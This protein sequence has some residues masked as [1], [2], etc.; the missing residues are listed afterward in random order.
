MK[1]WRFMIVIYILVSSQTGST[2]PNKHWRKQNGIL[3]SEHYSNEYYRDENLK[4]YIYT[5]HLH[6]APKWQMLHFDVPTTPEFSLYLKLK[7]SNCVRN[8][9]PTKSST[10]SIYFSTILEMRQRK[11]S[12]KRSNWNHSCTKRSLR[13]AHNRHFDK[14]NLETLNQVSIKLMEQA[15]RSVII[16]V[17]YLLSQLTI[18]CFPKLCIFTL[19]FQ[20]IFWLPIWIKL[21]VSNL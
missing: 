14:S 16:S 9:F 17:V 20:Q 12:I 8:T 21:E 19:L 13:F 4:K 2:S 15:Q 11:Q 5:Q 3:S 6:F 7:T 18:Q 1:T 10:S